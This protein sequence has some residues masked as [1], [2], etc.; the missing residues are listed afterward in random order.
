MSGETKPQAVAI[1]QVG[2]YAWAVPSAQSETLLHFCSTIAACGVEVSQDYDAPAG[3]IEWRKADPANPP[4][5][6]FANHILPSKPTD[7]TEADN[8]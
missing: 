8:E 4:K 7:E 3:V 2:S 1:I 6:Q 5:L